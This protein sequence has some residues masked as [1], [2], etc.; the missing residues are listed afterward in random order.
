MKIRFILIF[1]VCLLHSTDQLF[2][3]SFLPMHR[4]V[5]QEVERSKT[6]QRTQ[7]HLAVKPFFKNEVPDSLM[8]FFGKDTA[9]YYYDLTAALFRDHTA[10]IKR[11]DYRLALDV[12]YDF[13]S[14]RD[15]SE[16]SDRNENRFVFTNMRG[17]MASGDLGKKFTFYTGFYEMQR[18]TPYYQSVYIDSVGVFPG[19]GRVKDYRQN[20]YDHSMSFAGMRYQVLKN[21]KLDLVY[22]KQFVGFG[23]RSLLWSDASFAF[24]SL[25]SEWSF[26]D[27]KLKYFTSYSALQS[28]ERLPR[29]DVPESLF[30]RKTASF[31]YLS[32]KPSKRLELGLFEATMW[33]RVD[34]LQTYNL[35][36]NAYVPL[37]GASVATE[38]WQGANNTYAGI[39]L[40][41]EPFDGIVLYSQWLVN[42]TERESQGYQ[43]GVK[44]FDAVFKGLD[45][46]LEFNQ[47]GS[48]AYAGS[49][50]L[51]SVSHFNQPL[52]HPSFAT[53]QEWIGLLDYRFRRLIFR[54]RIVMWNTHLSSDLQR[55][56][57]L[58]AGYFV[59]P[60]T[61]SQISLSVIHRD[62]GYTEWIYFISIRTNLHNRYFDF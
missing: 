62:L 51:Q 45:F 60:K 43:M 2:G 21:W 47:L 57:E 53:N 34:S 20:G 50:M 46:Q 24:P 19:L 48:E 54:S 58:E 23:Y 5:W 13:S 38:G 32:F 18:V 26:M 39:N 42:N 55:H 41:F 44:L 31:N 10:Q 12:L 59:N 40:R 11:E 3:Q 52:G 17:L 16:R 9:K 7:V 15:F 28:L 6:N 25:R 37:I 4:D 1:L 61:N 30:K 33:R 8:R 14:G 29:R 49:S 56:M 36:W 27:G 35:P 22:D